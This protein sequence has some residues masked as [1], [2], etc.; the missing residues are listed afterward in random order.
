M[1]SYRVAIPRPWAVGASMDCL[2]V[3]KTKPKAGRIADR[4]STVRLMDFTGCPVYSF[5]TTP[6]SYRERT[7]PALTGLSPD[8]AERATGGFRVER[9]YAPLPPS[10][11]PTLDAN[12]VVRSQSPAPGTL[13]SPFTEVP[14]RPNPIVL[15]IDPR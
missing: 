2:V 6:D 4:G 13:M 9:Q 7:V 5:G 1:T 12:Y 11:L 10:A 3:T 8:A 14:F 15:D